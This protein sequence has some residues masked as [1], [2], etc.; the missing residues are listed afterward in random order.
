MSGGGNRS[1][2]VGRTDDI[3]DE[4]DER[5]TWLVEDEMVWGGS[6]APGPGA[7]GVPQQPAEE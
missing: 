1:A 5:L 2:L 7:L 3:G 6:D 4:A